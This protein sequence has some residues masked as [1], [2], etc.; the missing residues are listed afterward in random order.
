MDYCKGGLKMVNI[1]SFERTLKIKWVKQLNSQQDAWTIIPIKYNIHCLLEYGNK[2]PKKLLH[3]VNNPFWRSVVE[4]YAYVQELCCIDPGLTI[5]SEPIWY[6]DPIKIGY[7][8][9]SD[10][11][12][13]KCVGDMFN[14]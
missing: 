1:F 4:S 7:I 2:F 3:S 6:N 9:L 12:G 13:L 10:Q 8:K 5:P 11:K 14:T